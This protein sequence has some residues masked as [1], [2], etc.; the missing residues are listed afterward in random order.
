MNSPAVISFYINY[1]KGKGNAHRINW[2]F[3]KKKE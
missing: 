2:K 3:I 1:K